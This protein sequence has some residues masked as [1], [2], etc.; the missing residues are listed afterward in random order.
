MCAQIA[1]SVQSVYTTAWHSLVNQ[2]RIKPGE[3][4]LIHAAAGGVGHA[5]ISVC[6][7]MGVKIYATTS[8]AKQETV[9]RLG[10]ENIYDSRSTSWFTDVM[11]DTDGRGVDVVLNSLAGVHQRLGL[12]VRATHRRQAQPLAHHTAQ[13]THGARPLL[14]CCRSR[15]PP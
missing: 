15:L 8:A 14:T 1:A 13:L 5:A 12:Q 3:S 10:V 9:R 7:L 2:A 6:K 4:V 11:R